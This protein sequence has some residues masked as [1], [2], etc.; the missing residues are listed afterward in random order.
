MRAFQVT[1]YG[2]APELSK[3]AMPE[4]GP[5]ELRLM[6]AACGLNF[7]D[8]LMVTGEYQERP[9]L[10]FAL[11]ME[12]S[13]TVDALGEGVFLAATFFAVAWPAGFLVGAFVGATP[14]A[15]LVGP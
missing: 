11:G 4:P 9:P 7:A 5:G 8:L 6:V 10:P 1:E 3:I 12:M 13:G 14:V 15:A 2:K